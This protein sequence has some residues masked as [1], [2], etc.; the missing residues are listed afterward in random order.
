MSSQ[1]AFDAFSLVHF[2]IGAVAGYIGVPL[3]AF[4]IAHQLFELYENSDMGIKFF[5]KKDTILFQISPMKWP[6]YE[7]DSAANTAGDTL[8]GVL[9]WYVGDKL[10]HK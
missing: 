3:I 2:G 1:K 7:G 10:S 6:I 8:A 4:V 9:G 5:N